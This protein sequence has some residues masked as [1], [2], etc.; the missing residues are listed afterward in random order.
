MQK[1]R[2]AQ[3]FLA[4][5]ENWRG[6]LVLNTGVEAT[7]QHWQFEATHAP[8]GVLDN[9][10]F[11]MGLLRAYCDAYV[12]RRLIY[13]TELLE[14]AYDALRNAGQTGVRA[15]LSRR[16]CSTALTR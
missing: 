2:Q 5:K 7:L 12:R 16:A 1:H 10:R 6:A 15:A 3:S 13:E 4:L 14:Q 9:Y 8:E 11:Q